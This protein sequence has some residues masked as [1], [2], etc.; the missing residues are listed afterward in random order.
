MVGVVV[1]FGAMPILI[2]NAMVQ[3]DTSPRRWPCFFP[4]SWDGVSLLVRVAHLLHEPYAEF[5]GYQADQFISFL[6]SRRS[7]IHAEIPRTNSPGTSTSEL[8]ITPGPEAG[9]S[10]SLRPAAPFLVSPQR[11]LT[12]SR[13][14][15]KI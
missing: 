9:P 3:F 4:N 13:G 10:Y 7:G 11:R 12:G 8:I 14:R 1:A 5:R 6:T 15:I 2:T